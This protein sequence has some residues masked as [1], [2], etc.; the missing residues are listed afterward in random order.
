VIVVAVRWYLRCGL[1]YRDVEELLAGRGI[2]GLVDKPPVTWPLPGNFRYTATT[3]AC[4][5]CW[6]YEDWLVHI[7]N[8]ETRT[9]GS[10]SRTLNH[11]IDHR[12]HLYGGPRRLQHR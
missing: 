7:A 5:P 3:C 4:N 9:D 1:S 12:V 10:I 6:H 8:G 11:D 2:L